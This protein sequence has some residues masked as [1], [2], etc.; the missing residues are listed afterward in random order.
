ML[1][2]PNATFLEFSTVVDFVQ[3]GDGVAVTYK[4]SDGVRDVDAD[5]ILIADGAQ[6][7][8]RKKLNLRLEGETLFYNISYYFRSPAL[9]KLFAKTQ[10]SS[11]AFFVNE[12]AYGD[13]IVAQSAEDHWVYMISPIPEGHDPDDWDAVRAML[14]RSIGEEFE[15]FEPEGKIWASHSR[16]TPTFNFGRAFLIGDASHLTSPWGGFGMN[17]GIGDAADLG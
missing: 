1:E 10:L 13:L 6:S 2:L 7:E 17:M 12:D 9:T 5:Y 4:G 14:F 16:L 8:L 11:M 3:D 15:I